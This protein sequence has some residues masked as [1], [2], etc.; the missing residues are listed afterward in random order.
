MPLLR[1]DI[2]ISFIF[3]K[4]GDD[5]DS[6]IKENGKDAFYNLA[7]NSKSLSR[8]FFETL[9]KQDDLSSIEGRTI[10]AK[11]ALPLIKSISNET[12]KQAY[13]NEASNVCDIDFQKLIKGN[14]NKKQVDIVRKKPIVDSKSVIK[15]SV[16]G[17]FTALIQHPKHNKSRL[18]NL[19]N[20]DSKYS[21]MLDIRDIYIQHP[22]S[23]ASLILE[24]N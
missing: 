2:R 16:L 13:I 6:F 10:A 7:K 15:K 4:E 11:F 1:E 20:P 5:P 23:A 17:I 14:E 21:F 22:N 3:L 24:K 9:K 8:Y 12:I 18:F 19:I